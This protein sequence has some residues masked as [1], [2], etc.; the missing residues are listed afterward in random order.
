MT[1]S[2]AELWV[3]ILEK[4][5]AKLFQGYDRLAGVHTLDIIRAFTPAPSVFLNHDKTSEDD[6]WKNINS[7]SSGHD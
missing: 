7:N 4:A 2:H 3:S 1:T 6:I 5:F